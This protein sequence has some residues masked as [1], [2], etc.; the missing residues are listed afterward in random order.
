MSGLGWVPEWAFGMDLVAVATSRATARDVAGL[1]KIAH[2][3]SGGSLGDAG[4]L[5]K[6]P[7]AR[8]GLG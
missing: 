3:R 6:I 8:I 7:Q 1:F 4:L 2:D 5:G